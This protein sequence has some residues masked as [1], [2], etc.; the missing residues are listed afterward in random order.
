M[1]VV[2][3]SLNFLIETEGMGGSWKQWFLTEDNFLPGDVGQF[4][5][6]F[7]V[8]TTEGGLLLASSG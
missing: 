1:L 8:A 7:L 2:F 3:I 5:E 6:T 4:L